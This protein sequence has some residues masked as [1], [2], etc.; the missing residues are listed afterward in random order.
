MA[1]AEKQTTEVNSEEKVQPKMT[2][3]YQVIHYENGD[4]SIL[5][6]PKEGE[7]A[8]KTPVAV[9]FEDIQKVAK[10]VEDNR[11]MN[12]IEVG[13]RRFFENE[14]RRAEAEAKKAAEAEKAEPTV[15]G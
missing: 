7:D 2:L 11:L 4:T 1:E 3:G 12:L 15:E 8:S 9:I 14:Q 10:Q 13:V 6:I 5:P